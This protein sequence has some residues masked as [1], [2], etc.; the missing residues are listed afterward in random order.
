MRSVR[1]L[2]AAAEEAVEAAAWYEQERPGL[3]IE[4]AKAI[5]AALD[6]LETEIVPLSNM[7]GKFGR[8]SP[9]RLVLQR[10]PYDIVV[11]FAHNRK[12]QY[13][14]TT[15]TPSVTDLPRQERGN[16]NRTAASALD[17]DRQRHEI[18]TLNRNLFNIRDVLQRRNVVRH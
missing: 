16:A 6:L 8:P 10:F 11:A 12:R 1:I 4:F 17:F 15:D 2:E 14:R 7:P 5:D 9:K 18:R 3:G 13:A